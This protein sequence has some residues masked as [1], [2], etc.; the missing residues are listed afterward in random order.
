MYKEPQFGLKKY[1]D[2]HEKM[3]YL[4]SLQGM[5]KTLFEL[6]STCFHSGGYI[7]AYNLLKRTYSCKGDLMKEIGASVKS[8]YLK[9]LVNDLHKQ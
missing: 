7:L 6:A 9:C 2:D 1:E 8:F 4:K 3:N 5:T